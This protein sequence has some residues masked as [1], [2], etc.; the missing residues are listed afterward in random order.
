MFENASRLK[1]RFKTSVGQLSTEDLWD[2]SLPGLDNLAKSLNKE[3]KEASEESF[4]K[5]RTRANEILDLKFEL[6]KHVIKVKLEEAEARKIQAQNKVE[7][8]RLLALK[9]K[10]LGEA[11]DSLSVE[12]IDARLAQLK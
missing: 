3:I 8:E 12:D 11:L 2:L 5:T 1:L 10:K 6:V 7:R 9:D 4:I